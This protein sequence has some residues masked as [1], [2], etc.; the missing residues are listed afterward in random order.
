MH[1]ITPVDK[2]TTS[3]FL[4]RYHYLGTKGFRSSQIYGMYDNVMLL[5]VCVFHG[6]SAP[7][8]VVGAFG[9][10]RTEQDGIW[11][12]GRL[13][14]HP[15]LNGSNYTSWFVSRAL[16]QLQK[17]DNVR[18]VVSYADTSAGHLG[19]IYRATNAFYCGVTTLK[20]D[21]VDPVTNKVKER[22]SPSEKGTAKTYTKRWRPQKHRY[23]WV[24][25]PTLE[26]KWKVVS[27]NWE[28]IPKGIKIVR[29]DVT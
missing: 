24:F 14:M 28:G 29:S 15:T 4:S 19:S 27:C 5:G 7:E 26:L 8:T 11:E 10:Q 13:A 23:V 22:F 20:F 25:D 6:V 12:L 2:K 3:L 9:L 1:T 17:D 18:A 16:K 21:Y